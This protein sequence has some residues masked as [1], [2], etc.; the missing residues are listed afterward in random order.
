MSKYK[1]KPKA[2][3]TISSKKQKELLHLPDL[4]FVKY[5]EKEFFIN[6]GMYNTIENIFYQKG[7]T[8]ILDRRKLIIEFL[9][10]LDKEKGIKSN[11]RVK[12]GSHGLV[13]RI[14]VFL[15]RAH[16]LSNQGEIAQS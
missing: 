11:G 1:K 6:R 3:F 9:L 10:Y 16:T 14:N 13:T 8:Q 15:S 12:F 7:A 4:L 2:A 5:C